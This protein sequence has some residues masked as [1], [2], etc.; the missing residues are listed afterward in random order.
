MRPLRDRP[1]F[2]IGAAL[3][4]AVVLVAA[5]GVLAALPALLAFALLFAG[6]YPGADR[7]ERLIS[8]RCARPPPIRRRGPFARPRSASPGA[9]AS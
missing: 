4:A 6:R 1:G 8:G 3:V 5:A 2:A 9:A 7:L